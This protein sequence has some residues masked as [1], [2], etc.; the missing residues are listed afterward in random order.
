MPVL[1]N[2][3]AAKFSELRTKLLNLLHTT[4]IT[5]L[6]YDHL[7]SVTE[8]LQLLSRACTAGA[9]GTCAVELASNCAVV[10]VTVWWVC[11][12]LW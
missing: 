1:P 4:T 12:I 8:L 11:A 9:V 7:Y 3:R 6:I 10:S 2:W 5:S